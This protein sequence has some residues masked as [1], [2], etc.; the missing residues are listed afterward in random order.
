VLSTMLS[1]VLSEMLKREKS[2]KKSFEG[3]PLALMT[4]PGEGFEAPALDAS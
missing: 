2:R 1:K 4:N 3:C